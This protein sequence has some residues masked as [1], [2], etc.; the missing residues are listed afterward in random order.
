MFSL[1]PN[2]LCSNNRKP[3]QTSN[4]TQRTD[5]NAANNGGKSCCNRGRRGPELAAG[6]LNTALQRQSTIARSKVLSI[7]QDLPLSDRNLLLEDFRVGNDIIV[8]GLLVKLSF[9]G[10]YPCKLFQIAHHD[11]VVARTAAIKVHQNIMESPRW[12]SVQHV[13]N[14]T[15]MPL[16]VCLFFSF[17][18]CLFLGSLHFL[19]NS[20]LRLC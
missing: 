13:A 7:V 10:T 12:L 5:T 15:L 2:N 14:L 9:W 20:I 4:N 6:F 1:K 3:K 18:L 19:P 8:Q 17:F 16:C 11:P